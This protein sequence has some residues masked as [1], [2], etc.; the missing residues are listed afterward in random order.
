MKTYAHFLS[1]VTALLL[2]VTLPLHAAQPLDLSKD[3]REVVIPQKDPRKASL[4][5]RWY[6]SGRDFIDIRSFKNGYMVRQRSGGYVKF[7]RQGNGQRFKD[8]RGNLLQVVDRNTLRF[9]S[10]DG[11]EIRFYSRD[12]DRRIYENDTRRYHRNYGQNDWKQR[13]DRDRHQNS[14]GKGHLKGKGKGHHH[15]D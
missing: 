14:H 7:F 11:R 10:F 3:N 8:N 9:R 12:K 1:V 5:G 2:S 13:D 4:E 6:L 15:F